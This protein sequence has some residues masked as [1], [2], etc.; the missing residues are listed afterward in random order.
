MRR[1]RRWVRQAVGLFGAAQRDAELADEIE[2]HLQLHT[3]ENIRRGM[4]PD[5]ARR[6]AVLKLGSVES[7]KEQ[8]REQRGLPALERVVQD[9]R[10][11]AR[12]LRRSPGVTVVAGVTLA[13]GI[14]GPT[15]MFSMMKAWVL[16]PLPFARPDTLVDIRGIDTI[17]GNARRINPAD[18]LDWMRT[19]RSFE[20]LAAYH[21]QEVRLTGGDRADRV[22]GARV[23]ANF[24]RLLETRAEVGRLLTPRDG[25]AGSDRVAVISHG[26][27]RERFNT[28]PEIVGRPVHMDGEVFTVVG[29]LPEDFH[30]TLLG[31]VSV[32]R[33]LVFTP[34]EAANRQPRSIV[35]LGRLRQGTSPDQAREDLAGIARHLATAYPDTNAARGVRVLPLADE[36]RLHHDAGFLVPVIFA[37]VGCVLLVACVNVTNVMLARA[38]ARQH[39]IAVRLALGAS[40]MRIVHQWLVEHLLLFVSASVVGALLAIYLAAWV[41]NSIPAENRTY[42]R[43]YGELSIDRVVLCFAIGIGAAC[44]VLFGWLPARAS[45]KADVNVDLRDGAGRTTMSKGGARLRASL[46][47][48]E[49]ALSLALLISAALLVETARHITQVDVG[50]SPRQ[51]LTFVLDLD[52]RRY[53]SPENVRNFYE[54]LIADLRGRPGILTAAAS[55]LVPFGSTGGY[56]EFFL[57]GRADPAPKDTPQASVSRVTADYGR[58]LGVRLIRG[59]LLNQD[60]HPDGLK[61]AVVNE[62]LAM[63]YFGSRDPIGQRLRVGRAS[64]DYWTIVGIVD[65]VMN[66][67]TVSGHEPQ[68]YVPFPQ[69]P[70]R[71][72]TVVIRAADDPGA[73]VGTVRGAVAAVDPAEPVSRVFTMPALIGQFTAPYQTTSTFVLFFGLVTV[74]LAGVGVYGVI[75]YT[76][77]Q[78]TREIGIRMAL[79]AR[80]LD[81]AALVLKQI[82]TVLLAGMVPGLALAWGLGQALK[83]FLVGV[84]P[85]DW[86]VYLSMCALLAAVAFI[87]ALVPARR[88]MRVDPISALRYE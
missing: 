86:R 48:A 1:L 44:G 19:A 74:V 34:D 60:D 65:D 49:V 8:Y 79:G 61:V 80:G 32:W 16:D 41:T 47:G 7:V 70:A 4:S 72:M 76:F 59:R 15:V 30:F 81:V 78:R 54:R 51:V 38:T 82:R 46:V 43:N 18:F 2:S 9:L 63:R 57:E 84:T 66:Y 33:P 87:A 5:A 26:L 28:D 13:L 20:Q 75:S 27:W 53:E 3:E 14:A 12:S 71:E 24:F 73:L 39:E 36:V 55:S 62:T 35:G 25:Q 58:T 52:E 11:A 88:A 67:D 21:G 6:A 10:Y 17:T 22:H 83:A 77:A 56:D 64:T 50:F 37:M 42:L 23:T 31:R 68:I 85:T 29:V 40:R 69:W 45:A